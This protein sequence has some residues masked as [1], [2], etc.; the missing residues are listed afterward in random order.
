MNGND[1][2]ADYIVSVAWED[3]P[4]E[5]KDKAKVCLLDALSA[6]VSGRLVKMTEIT[7]RFVAKLWPNAD[8]ATIYLSGK[9]SIAE[10]AA[11]VNAN[12]ANGL[13]ID[14]NGRYTRGH[15][16]AQIIPVA[17]ATG[18]RADA[19]GREILT[20]IVIGYEVAHR[21]GRIWHTV[22]NV[23][24]ACGSWGSVANAAVASRIMGLNR[25]QTRHA[26]GIAD[27]H[28][29]NLPM[30]RAIDHPAMVKHGIGWAAMGG[31]MAAGLA[32]E[33]YTG[34]PSMLGMD[35][36]KDWLADIGKN[37]IMLQGVTFKKHASCSWGHPPFASAQKLMK[38]H[39]ISLEQIE[40]IKITGFHEM[41]RLGT[42]R[43]SCE[44]EAQFNVAWPL[45]ALLID[46]EVGPDQMLARRLGDPNI[47]DLV[48]KVELIFSEELDHL[49]K[50][51]HYPCAVEL[52]LKDGSTISSG[53]EEYATV[54]KGRNESGGDLVT[55]EE[56]KEKFRWICK[57]V[58]NPQTIEGCIAL[59]DDFQNQPNLEKLKNLLAEKPGS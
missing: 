10:G 55:A 43:P 9:R 51:K 14:D 23:Y 29:P 4:A 20:A 16:G 53:I 3:L 8:E 37:Y 24:Q 11:F 32:Q 7:E 17:L 56:V 39:G 57:Y 45:A 27:Y 25:E 48:S 52:V 15:P 6:I 38:A 21:I 19:S 31:I 1:M 44:E 59:V 46:G 33:G 13:D 47:L 49:Y 12:A 22:H 34:V 36:Y 18:E 40:K 26:L 58:I 2:A 35:E 42:R 30:M 5:V 54:G 50:A 41:V 28:A